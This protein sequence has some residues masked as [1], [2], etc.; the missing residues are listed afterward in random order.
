MYK[1]ELELE[2]RLND[3]A[4]ANVPSTSFENIVIVPRLPKHTPL[5]MSPDEFDLR[6]LAI[7][8][9]MNVIS[10]NAIVNKLGWKPSKIKSDITK[11]MIADYQLEMMRNLKNGKYVPAS[12]D[13]DLLPEPVPLEVLNPRG[14]TLATRQLGRTTAQIS[15]LQEILSG[16]PDRWIAFKGDWEMRRGEALVG[17]DRI[18]S[19]PAR[20][21][22]KA[23]IMKRAQD[24]L[25]AMGAEFG[26]ADVRLRTDLADLEGEALALT[27]SLTDSSANKSE[28]E[29]E[30][31]E[32]RKENARRRLLFEDQVR[33][34][35]TG[36]NFVP[37]LPDE[38][39]EE[40]RQ[41]LRDI[42][43][44]TND[45]DAV[46][47]AAE[48]L[49]SDRLRE[50]MREI[51]R[52]D[53][54]IGTF[55]AS[56][57]GENRYAINKIWE[58][59]KKKV[60]EIFGA[61]NPN[62]SVDDLVNISEEM[63]DIVVARA[64]AEPVEFR[65]DAYLDEL[66]R[67]PLKAVSVVEGTDPAVEAPP[68]RRPFFTYP[69]YKISA[70]NAGIINVRTQKNLED[71]ANGVGPLPKLN[72]KIEPTR[73]AAFRTELGYI[74]EY[75]RK[76][77]KAMDKAAGGGGGEPLPPLRRVD[78]GFA[79]PEPSPEIVEIPR[80]GDL[81]SELEEILADQDAIDRLQAIPT[82]V[83]LVK[84]ANK[85]GIRFKFQTG[86]GLSGRGI[87]D[88]YPKIQ[89]FGLIEIS[90]HKLFY[91]NVLK[92]TRK[93]KHLTGFPNV[94]VS[95]EF[96]KFMFKIMDGAQP[97]LRDV[98][99]LSVGEKQ[100]FDSVVFT[101]GLQKKVESTG[102]GVKQKLKDRLAL[103]E[104]EIEAGNTADDLI[105]EARQILQHLARMRII[106]HR[107]ASGHLKQL[108]NAQR[109]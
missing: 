54:L 93:G 19:L 95:N 27:Q 91:E 18:A 31:S 16:L 85:A 66:E 52:D 58:S 29:R 20:I 40:Y 41:R 61:N 88:K 76:R 101:A 11:E 77:Q 108:I 14:Q 21:R 73:Q 46:Q 62:L 90:P 80:L 24:E 97:T 10:L 2:K 5:E 92:I 57:T 86:R 15:E 67:T 100:L 43:D 109:G 78:E 36:L 56:L 12:I 38:T 79:S 34:L 6:D 25:E 63:N 9:K 44:S 51:T 45:G 69:P 106:G 23:L 8:S 32:V 1:T 89:P 59:F 83:E 4:L 35:N 42:G 33:T 65:E 103:I 72:P 28:Y 84:V 13:L 64:I 26:N 60:L 98:N 75:R 55:I 3:I 30:L 22:Q 53:A 70:V 104:G 81:Q 96:V 39:A 49:N 7:E 99:Q 68:T 50:R 17:A 71:Y 105:K 94:K 74:D 48:L 102:S 82:A 87:K 47:A 37:M 107:A